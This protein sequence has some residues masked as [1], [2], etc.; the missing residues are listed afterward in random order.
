MDFFFKYMEIYYY[1][2]FFL[3]IYKN[4]KNILFKK[5]ELFNIK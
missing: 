2:Y 1:Y 5:E 4:R 3:T